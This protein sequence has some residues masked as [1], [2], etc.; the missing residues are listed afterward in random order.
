[1]LFLVRHAHAEYGPDEM[2]GLSPAGRAEA[3]HVAD[4]LASQGIA[5]IYSSPYARAIETVQP[6][7][8]RLGVPIAIDDDLR[9]R[10]LAGGPLDDFRAVLE[11]T[12]RDFGL[13]P[14]GGESSAAAQARVTRAIRRIG[15]TTPGPIAIASH[16][17][18][19]ALFLHTLD[20]G[21]DFS[22]WARMSTP[23]V[24]VVERAGPDP[25]TFRRLWS[26]PQ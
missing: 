17:N 24:F 14:P 15:A 11:A 12:W 2:R 22:F 10:R 8:D 18:A 13:V 16:G 26:E 6:L 7:A 3:A 23:D 20:A 21:V 4:V 9:E 5:R 19:L 25:W 1:M